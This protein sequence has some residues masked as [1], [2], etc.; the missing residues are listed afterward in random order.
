MLR[1]RERRMPRLLDRYRSLLHRA[2]AFRG[3]EVWPERR[4][5]DCKG[6]EFLYHVILRRVVRCY[7]VVHQGGWY[8]I[9]LDI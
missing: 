5:E 1:C 7:G 2:L 8:C 3:Y 6:L 9:D 4:R